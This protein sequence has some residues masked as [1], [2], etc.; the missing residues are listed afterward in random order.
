MI[1]SF[2][3]VHHRRINCMINDTVI[4][5]FS[6]WSM[7]FLLLIGFLIID[8]F[9]VQANVWLIQLILGETYEYIVVLDGY[10]EFALRWATDSRNILLY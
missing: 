4:E 3:C 5:W 7:R 1:D 8:W 6:G 2:L 9:R 10:E